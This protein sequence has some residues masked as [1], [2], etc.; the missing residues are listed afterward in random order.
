MSTVFGAQPPVSASRTNTIHDSEEDVVGSKGFKLE[1][2]AFL[3]MKNPNV[4]VNLNLSTPRKGG[5]LGVPF[6]LL[7]S[8]RFCAI[9]KRFRDESP[10]VLLMESR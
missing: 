10:S 4:D 1:Q 2:Q 5:G 9:D 8:V 6:L 3:N 7:S